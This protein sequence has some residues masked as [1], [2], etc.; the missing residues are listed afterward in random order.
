MSVEA[1]FQPFRL[2]SLQLKNRIVM[3]P[4]T[5]SHSP[6]GLPTQ[7]VADYY[8][9]RGGAEVGLIVSEGTAIERA[10]SA[11][12]PQVPRFWG[13]DAL[14]GW[15]RVID[16]VHAAGGV[17]APQLWHVGSV[18]SP[19]QTWEPG[20]I[21]SPSGIGRIDQPAVAEP[22]SDAEI[23]DIIAAY[24]QAAGDAKRLGFDAVELHGAHG[25]LID[26]FF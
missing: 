15:K 13:E 1:L 2:K 4:M 10:A 19:N 12:D 7:A 17:M 14:A 6:G 22:L 24:G 26:Q 11:N 18:K 23:A 16:E 5:R 25:Y 9:R 3:A 8:A 20:R 21:D